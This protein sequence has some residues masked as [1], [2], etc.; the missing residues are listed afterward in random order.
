MTMKNGKKLMQPTSTKLTLK[1]SVL[2]A[3]AF[4]ALYDSPLHLQRIRELLNQSAT[5]EEVQHILSKLVEDNKI[6]QA[7]NLY[8]LKPWQASDYRD[9]QIEIS[10]KWQKIDSYYKWL[11]V[12]P[13]VRLVSVINS[14]SLGTADAD[15]DID[16]F[17]VTKNRRLYFVRSVIIVLFR[18]LGVYKTRERIKD[19]FCFGFFVTQNNLNLE[20]L[21]IKPADPY[22]D[23]WLASMRPVVGG[24]QY[25]ELM[26]QNS[27]LRAKF[28][29][30]EP[31]NRHATLK[32]TNIFLR[33]ISL[34]LEILLYIPA[35]LAEPWL[36]RI[37]ITHTFK[38]AENHAVTSTTVAN[39]TM[40]KLHAHDVRAQVA[41][42]HKDLLQS[43]R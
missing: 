27:W 41:N 5:L 2:S 17:V 26:Q 6:F 20:S 22:L 28:P 7:G 10:K 4:F 37:H 21:Q 40:L 25:W 31:I 8:S 11:A 12:L 19:K 14:L 36:R 42:A 34:I 24:Q 35:E 9:R 1:E 18:L 16:F 23:F 38:L 39:A 43:F 15:S 3:L 29:N 13:F 30:F 33:T 32:K